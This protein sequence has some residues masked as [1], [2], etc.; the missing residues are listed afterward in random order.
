MTKPAVLSL[1]DQPSP[2]HSRRSRRGSGPV[3]HVQPRSQAQ[4]RIDPVGQSSTLSEQQGVACPGREP[5]PPLR[6]LAAA[7]CSRRSRK[8]A[9]DRSRLDVRGSSGLATPSTSTSFTGITSGDGI[10]AGQAP[11]ARGTRRGAVPAVTPAV[12][13]SGLALAVRKPAFSAAGVRELPG[14]CQAAGRVTAPS[15]SER[16]A[17]QGRTR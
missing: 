12:A 10:S 9:M 4:V 2:E 6:G 15:R 8:W 16:R 11:A 14:Y 7:P 1:P 3:S 5:S 13:R 17:R